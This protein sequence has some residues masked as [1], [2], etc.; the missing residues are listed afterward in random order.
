MTIYGLVAE[1][2]TVVQFVLLIL[3]IASVLS[4]ACIFEKWREL[5]VA[6]AEADQF[7]GKFWGGANLF[8]LHKDYSGRDDN[9]GMGEVFVS[10]FSEFQRLR[11]KGAFAEKVLSDGVA[12]A[13]RVA[14]SRLEEQ[15]E[16]RLNFLATVGSVSPYVGL[17][18]TVWGIMHAFI[19]LSDVHQA[20]LALVAPG[21]AEAL[22][23]TAMGLVAAIPAVIAYNR[24]REA[25]ERLVARYG[26]FVEEFFGI[27]SAQTYSKGQA[28]E[29]RAQAYSKGQADETRAQAYSKGQA[30]E[31]VGS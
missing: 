17:F 8:K 28:D 14:V 3:L 10:G 30:D 1:S 24:Y 19:A 11:K 4:W 5:K 13:M 27:L 31:T 22:V 16:K 25:T 12:R 9:S 15:L 23:A 7:E 2:G 29:T 6:R 26:N 18:G 21:I 20:T